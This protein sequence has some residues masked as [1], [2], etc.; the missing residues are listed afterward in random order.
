[1][2][3]RVRVLEVMEPPDGTTRYADQLVEHLPESV[4]IVWF[5]WRRALTCRYD[6]LH[7]HWPEWLVR[8]RP[9]T[10]PRRLAT[11]AA[12]VA[13]MLRLRVTRTAIVRTEHNPEP[14]EPGGRTERALLRWLDRRTSLRVHLNAL[15]GGEG[16]SDVVI[17]LGH[18]REQFGVHPVS[19]RVPGLL[20]YFGKIRDYKGVDLLLEAFAAARADLSLRVV[21]NPQTPQWRSLV[22]DAARADPRIGYVLEFVADDTL[23]AEVTAAELAVLPYRDLHNSSVVLV[24]LSLD[25]PVLIP[26]TPVTRAIAEEVGPGWVHFFEGTLDTADVHRAVDALRAAPPT[27]RPLLDARAWDV[28]GASYARAFAAATRS[29]ALAR[30]STNHPEPAQIAR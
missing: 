22:E 23:V 7:V 14:H 6:V 17:P 16:P 15:P 4:D 10:L 20:V 26:S 9:S 2:T 27:G 12:F 30:P 3:P 18:Y 24:A 5:T 11:R 13:L 25:T 1:M 29:S 21:G 8:T 28:I 19:T